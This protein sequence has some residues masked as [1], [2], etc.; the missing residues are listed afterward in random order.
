MKTG[1]SFNF[2]KPRLLNIFLTLL[3]LCL[4]LLREEYNHGEYVTWHRPIGL[5][6]NSLQEP[7]N[8]SYRQLFFAA[9][10]FYLVVYIVVSFV[11]KVIL[12]YLIPTVKKLLS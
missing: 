3:V 6:I 7:Q 5:I 9:V 11:I 2:L 8:P 4:P 1:K 12:N 10:V